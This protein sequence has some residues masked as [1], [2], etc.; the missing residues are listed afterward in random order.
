MARSVATDDCSSWD[1]SPLGMPLSSTPGHNR[2][3]AAGWP[4]DL[5]AVLLR[6]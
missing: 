2:M 5:A 4:A 6:F 1:A 3:S